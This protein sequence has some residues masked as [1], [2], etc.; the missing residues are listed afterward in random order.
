LIGFALTATSLF[1]YTP[2]RTID[3]LVRALAVLLLWPVFAYLSGW[4]LSG[5]SRSHLAWSGLIAGS[6]ILFPLGSGGT[7]GLLNGALDDSPDTV[8]DAVIVE[9]YTSKSK[10]KTN[11][12]VRV[13]SWLP[14]GGTISYQVSAGEYNAIVPHRSKLVVTTRAG[15]LGVEWLRSRRVDARP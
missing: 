7:T 2:I 8:H 6:L 3:L 4:V 1:T 11:Y 5:T 9:K 14:D 12:H 15:W 13:A 10:N